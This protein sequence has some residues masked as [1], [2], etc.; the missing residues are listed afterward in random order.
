MAMEI[1]PSFVLKLR[2]CE[3]NVCFNGMNTNDHGGWGERNQ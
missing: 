2:P 1:V 3:I